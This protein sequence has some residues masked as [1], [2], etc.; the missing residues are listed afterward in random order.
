MTKKITK[1]MKKNREEIREGLRLWLSEATGGCEIQSG[2]VKGKKEDYG[3]PC[4]TCLVGIL[5]E[6]GLK[7]QAEE[8]NEH[9]DEV[10]RA[11]EVWRAILQIR[12][13]E[14]K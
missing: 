12:D 6:I 10:D 11:N 2:Y 13:A 4:G 3:W 14:L 7:P 8:Y 9:N 1:I 5:N